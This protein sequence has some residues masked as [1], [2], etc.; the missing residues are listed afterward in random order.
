MN[1][2]IHFTTVDQERFFRMAGSS[3]AVRHRHQF[4]L[5]AT[6]EL[7]AVIPHEVLICA[8]PDQAGEVARVERFSMHPAKQSE[9]DEMTHP[10]SGLLP[11]IIATWRENGAQPHLLS[12]TING[13]TYARFKDDLARYDL[14]NIASHG[15][16]DRNGN[17]SSH[18]SLICIPEPL[19][20]R[21]TILMELVIPYMKAALTRVTAADSQPERLRAQSK[22]PVTEREIEIL[23]W[24]QQ[25]KSNAQI[26]HQLNISPL[27]VKN[28]VQNILKKLH[29]Q[30]RAEAV[31]RAIGSRLITP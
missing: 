17:V 2:F 21:H 22:V 10:H 5:W 6:G 26:G 7:Q 13:Q 20:E 9:F 30:N 8:L 3:I 29:V 31:S 28:H 1:D 27:T 16:L 15:T 14:T 11:R 25:G 23:H 4:F 12:P 19:T 18:F 24:V